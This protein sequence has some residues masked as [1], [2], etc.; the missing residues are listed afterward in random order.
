LPCLGIPTINSFKI[1]ETDAFD[2]E[3]GGILKQR[4]NLD[5]PKQIVRFHSGV[6]NK[7][8]NN[9]STIKKEIL[10]IVLCI[11]NFQTDLLNKKFLICIGC[12]SAKYVL[13]K[14][15]ENIALKH[16]FAR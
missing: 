1:V 5:S 4:I 12:K 15:V 16:I 2:I 11:D 3:Y 7:A 10:S 9:Y 8:Q 13:E 14:D 6:W